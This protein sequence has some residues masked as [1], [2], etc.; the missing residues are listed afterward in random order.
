MITTLSLDVRTVVVLFHGTRLLLLRRAAWKT[1]APNRWTGLG[2][3][4][5]PDEIG[6][7][8]ASARRETFEETDLSPSEVSGL[9]LHRTLTFHH[10]VEGLV[11][12]LYFA[13][14]TTTD[15]TPVCTEGSLAWVSVDDLPRLDFIENTGQVLPLLIEDVR[16]QDERVHCGVAHYDEKGHLQ[17]IVFD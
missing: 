10:P 9:R 11:C 13:G 6:D 7:L 1:F 16:S 4:V 8:E 14:T 3:K 15:R 17:R 2:G 12:L 5:E